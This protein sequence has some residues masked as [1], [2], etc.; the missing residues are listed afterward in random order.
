MSSII[1]EQETLAD[2][3]V[4]SVSIPSSGTVDLTPEAIDAIADEVML[5]LY[6]I[7]VRR[8]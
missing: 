1:E 3:Y 7:P 8:L 6:E 2:Q 5:R 4:G